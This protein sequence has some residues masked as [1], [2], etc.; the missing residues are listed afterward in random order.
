MAISMG[1]GQIAELSGPSYWQQNQNGQ[2][3]GERYSGYEQVDNPYYYNWLPNS[4][5]PITIRSFYDT[6]S[7]PTETLIRGIPDTL[8]PNDYLVQRMTTTISIVPPDPIT[9]GDIHNLLG[10]T[11]QQVTLP[12][13]LADGTKYVKE[14]CYVGATGKIL[15][16]YICLP[17]DPIKVSTP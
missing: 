16:Q 8:F 4:S 7:I 11:P 17:S 3:L 6:S 12:E 1:N 10:T 9:E 2:Y 14:D 5:D 15:Q 13:F